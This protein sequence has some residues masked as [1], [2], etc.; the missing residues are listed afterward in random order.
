MKFII[1]WLRNIF[2]FLFV[3]E[4]KIEPKKPNKPK[5]LFEYNLKVEWL[6]EKAITAVHHNGQKL[7]WVEGKVE[8]Q[9]SS[10][11]YISPKNEGK[12]YHIVFLPEEAKEK[13]PVF[14]NG[15]DIGNSDYSNAPGSEW[16]IPEH[17]VKQV[18]VEIP[19]NSPWIKNL[20]ANLGKPLDK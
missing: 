18:R 6:P 11:I 14:V 16:G 13:L 15:I 1:D 2:S 5:P 9:K 17:T 8:N 4:E 12:H 19:S 7:L 3:E 20:A 10:H